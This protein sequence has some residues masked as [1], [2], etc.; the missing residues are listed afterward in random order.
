MTMRLQ[1]LWI[2]L[3]LVG[4]GAAPAAAPAP[5]I[6]APTL[7]P[8]AAPG[9]GITR[10]AVQA[11]FAGAPF[12]ATFADD[13]PVVRGTSPLKINVLLRG[14]AEN[15][16]EAQ[17]SATVGDNGAASGDILRAMIALLE[18][19]APQ[20]TNPTE[21]L[22][23]HLTAALKTGGDTAIEGD[24]TILLLSVPEAKLLSLSVQPRP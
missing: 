4:C 9:L 20:I 5:T 1:V 2:V 12:H 19:A 21:W 3:A 17:V 18:V 16:T 24:R 13:G 6:V 15:L 11:R 10:A 22:Q 23:P 14:P 8:T 7:A